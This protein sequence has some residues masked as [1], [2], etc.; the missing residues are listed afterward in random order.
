[1]DFTKELFLFLQHTMIKN[2]QHIRYLCLFVLW[3]VNM[4]CQPGAKKNKM[5]D[6]GTA[7]AATK[8]GSAVLAD[9][10]FSLFGGTVGKYSFTF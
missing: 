2:L 9:N 1:M 7:L 10:S 3:G 4:G 6:D 8:K 5:T